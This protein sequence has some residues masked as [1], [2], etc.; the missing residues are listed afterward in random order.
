MKYKKKPVVI[1]AIQWDGLNLSE[2]QQFVGDSLKST[3]HDAGWKAGVV[4]PQVELKINTLEGEMLVSK[5][6]YIIK[7]IANEFY[8]CKPN[9]FNETY[10][11]VGD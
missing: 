1:E 7:G 10:E 11:L 2:L 6:D 8:P 5:G 3:V 4:P 9:I